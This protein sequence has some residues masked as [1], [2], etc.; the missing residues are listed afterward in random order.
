M[1]TSRLSTT[2]AAAL[3]GY[4]PDKTLRMCVDGKFPNASRD[5]NGGHWRIPMSDIEAF[6]EANRPRVVRRRSAA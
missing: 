3:L 6:L 4:S 1:E 2:K 5:G